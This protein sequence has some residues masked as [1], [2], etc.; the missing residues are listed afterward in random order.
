MMATLFL[1][2][3]YKFEHLGF[4]HHQERLIEIKIMQ[5]FSAP[6][7]EDV[8]FYVSEARVNP[9]S[10]IYQMSNKSL[11]S[12]NLMVDIFLDFAHSPQCS[13]SWN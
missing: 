4:R 5:Y 8:L 12:P 2:D 11:S 9:I 10:W 13:T 1:R 3:T 6:L 7:K